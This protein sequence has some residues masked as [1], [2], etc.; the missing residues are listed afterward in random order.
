MIMRPG[1]VYA[2]DAYSITQP[3]TWL[4]PSVPVLWDH[5]G[6]DGGGGGS[7]NNSAGITSSRKSV[8]GGVCE[9]TRCGLFIR[10]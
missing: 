1:P 5:S 9:M 6:G 10:T 4:P 2:N 3:V 7:S 8:S